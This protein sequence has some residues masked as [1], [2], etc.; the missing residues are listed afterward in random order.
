[1]GLPHEATLGGLRAQNYPAWQALTA[2]AYLQT[3]DIPEYHAITVSE[4]AEAKSLN[5]VERLTSSFSELIT[6]ELLPNFRTVNLLY[7]FH[8]LRK[9]GEDLITA[10]G[11]QHPSKPFGQVAEYFQR[12][13]LILELA[14]LDHN[15][16]Q[17]VWDISNKCVTAALSIISGNITPNTGDSNVYRELIQGIVWQEHFKDNLPPKYKGVGKSGKALK[18]FLKWYRGKTVEMEDDGN[19]RVDYVA[20]GLKQIDVRHYDNK[21]MRALESYFDYN[22]TDQTLSEIIPPAATLNIK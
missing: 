13:N 20:L 9:L 1:M 11:K 3:L 19:H 7:D 15:T 17:K 4:F 14:D 21:L 22:T 18:F 2:A 5:I 10:A 8:E 16:A 12:V 6:N